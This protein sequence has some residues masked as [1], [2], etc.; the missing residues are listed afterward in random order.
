MTKNESFER[1][2][3]KKRKKKKEEEVEEK[4][5]SLLHCVLSQGPSTFG[6]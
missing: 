5:Y 6:V 4:I 3:K 1:E 2:T